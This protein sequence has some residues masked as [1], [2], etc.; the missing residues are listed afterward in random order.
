MHNERVLNILFIKPIFDTLLIKQNTTNERNTDRFNK[1]NIPYLL[2]MEELNRII[3]LLS[4]SNNNT[5]RKSFAL[6]LSFECKMTSDSPPSS[7]R[8][9]ILYLWGSETSMRLEE[10]E[11]G[12][13]VVILH[14]IEL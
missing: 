13:S 3:S 8:F 1:Q 9:S 11:G 7:N 5:N 6:V 4:L 14:L 2:I 12:E 10:G